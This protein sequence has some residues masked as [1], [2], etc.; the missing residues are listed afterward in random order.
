MKRRNLI[1]SLAIVSVTLLAGCS[2][3]YTTGDYFY[4]RNKG[5]DMPVWVTGNTSSDT[6]ILFLHGGPGGNSS[7]AALFPAFAELETRYAVAYWDQ[8]ASG[9]SQGN[10]DPETYTVPQFVEDMELV[11]DVLIKLYA[12]G[13]LV[14][15]GHSWGGALGTAYLADS[16]RA[17]KVSGFVMHDAG[18][19]LVDGLPASGE[20]MR[21]YAQDQIDAGVDPEYWTD[22]RDWLAGTPDFTVEANYR[23]LASS[24]SVP[25]RADAYYHDAANKGVAGPDAAF[26][27]T[28]FASLSLLTGGAS[29]RENFNILELDLSPELPSITLPTLV[30]WGRHDGVN[31]VEMGQDAFALLGTAPA[32]KSIVIFEESGHQPFVEEPDL[33][34]SEFTSFVDG[35]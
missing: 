27:F 18:Y 12:P 22:L 30:M 2:S 14:V 6:M 5:A 15:F 9:L 4:V 35:L 23:R 28:S 13:R 7:T 26:I 24:Y 31:T 34:V 21:A 19:N 16:A 33:F 25:G 17:A 20:W 3:Y 29:I 8:R 1:A 32:E 11:V 10:P